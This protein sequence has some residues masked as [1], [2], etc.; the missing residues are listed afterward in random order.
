[1]FD[2]QAFVFLIFWFQIFCGFSGAN[3][4]EQWYLLIFNLVFTSVPPLVN[5]VL[6]KDISASTLLR[7]PELYKQGINDEV[8]VN[9]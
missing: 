2:F 4:I 7:K 1:M 8:G 5:G 9:V 3:M 6:D